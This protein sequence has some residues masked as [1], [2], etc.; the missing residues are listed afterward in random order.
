M[1]RNFLRELI[2]QL[3]D[4]VSYSR[5]QLAKGLISQAL[6]HDPPKSHYLGGAVLAVAHSFVHRTVRSTHIE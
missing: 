6:L 2:E 5:D 4:K 3:K 1:L